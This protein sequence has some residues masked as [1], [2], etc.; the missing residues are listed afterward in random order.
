MEDAGVSN[1]TA[2]LYETETDER[3]RDELIRN[4]NEVD[5]IMLG[6]SSAVKAFAGMTDCNKVTAKI[7]VI[8]PETAKMCRKSGINGYIMAERYDISGMIEAVAK[9]F[10]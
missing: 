2:V 3:R 1:D 4:I 7:V 5:Y 10:S 6:S 9:D 8:G